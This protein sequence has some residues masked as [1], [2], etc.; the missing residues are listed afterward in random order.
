[1]TQ[2]HRDLNYSFDP[3][4]GNTKQASKDPGQTRVAQENQF[5]M[6]HWSLTTLRALL[7]QEPTLHFIVFPPTSGEISLTGS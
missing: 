1:M 6:W 3:G 7:K 5:R 4:E 2:L